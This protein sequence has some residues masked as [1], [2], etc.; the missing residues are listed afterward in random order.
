MEPKSDPEPVHT[1]E[2]K[3]AHVSEA[4]IAWAKNEISSVS[5]ARFEVAKFFFSASTVATGFFVAV[6]KEFHPKAPLSGLVFWG[7]ATL[8][9]SVAF[10]LYMF[11][12]VIRVFEEV[13]NI[14]REHE[15]L[16]RG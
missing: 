4:L 13:P 7:L 10:A 2:L 9:C 3:P 8:C 6:W 1:L 12:P 16:S 5:T 15:D 14:Q 11:W